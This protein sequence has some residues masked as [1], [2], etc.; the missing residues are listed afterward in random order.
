MKKQWPEYTVAELCVRTCPCPY[1]RACRPIGGPSLTRDAWASRRHV[2]RARRTTYS[3]SRSLATLFLCLCVLLCFCSR[4]SLTS[5]PHRHGG[6]KSL[7]PTAALLA[8]APERPEL[9]T[10]TPAYDHLSSPP[11]LLTTNKLP[12]VRGAATPST[13]GGSSAG[14]LQPRR[15]SASRG[16]AAGAP[17][18]RVA[19]RRSAVLILARSPLVAPLPPGAAAP[20]APAGTAS[21]SSSAL[22]STFSSSIFS[23][24]CR[25]RPSEVPWAGDLT[26]R[27]ASCGTACIIRPTSQISKRISAARART[28]AL[29]SRQL[30]GVILCLAPGCRVRHSRRELG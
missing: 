28:A 5:Q 2:P 6:N 24:S 29:S 25:C 1:R 16:T 21:V 22:S 9:N 4:H 17:A 11:P 15:P 23:H 13:S 30:A 14:A 7:A 18:A 10:G 26:E 8:A 12:E 20:H 27:K 3:R 19:A